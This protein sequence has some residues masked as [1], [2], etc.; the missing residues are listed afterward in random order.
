MHVLVPTPKRAQTPIGARRVGGRWKQLLPT[1]CTHVT[2][3]GLLLDASLPRQYLD[4]CL[5]QASVLCVT[6]TAT[7]VK[8]YLRYKPESMTYDVVCD[9]SNA[10]K[11]SVTRHAPGNAW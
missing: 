8:K 9:W 3:Y 11:R 1:F 2:E 5:L 10:S 7:G 6:R 4:F